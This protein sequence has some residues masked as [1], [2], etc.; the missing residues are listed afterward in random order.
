MSDDLRKRLGALT[1]AQRRL[2]ERRIAA[3]RRAAGAGALAAPI[4]KAAGDGPY[5]L[6]WSQERFWFLER[7]EPGNPAH[8][9]PGIALLAGPLD[10]D[11]F[12]AALELL[13]E[14]HAILRTIY[15]DTPDGPLQRVLPSA[16]LFFEIVDLRG[17]PP[18]ERENERARLEERTVLAPFDL[19]QGPVVRMRLLRLADGVHQLVSCLHH[20]AA[21]GLTMQILGAEAAAAYP[22]LVERR[23]PRLPALPVQYADYAVWQRTHLAGEHL[24]RG[25]AWWVERLAGLAELALPADRPRRGARADD[26]GK[27]RRALGR[28]AGLDL[29]D[30]LGARLRALA[31]AEGAT[32]FAVLLAAFQALL[33]RWTGEADVA[34]GTTAANRGRAELAGLVGFFVNT[35]VL[36]T[37]LAGDPSFRALLARARATSLGA[38]DHQDV[39]FERVVDALQPERSLEKH[40]LFQA[41]FNYVEFRGWT[42]PL[43]AGVSMEYRLAQAGTLFDLTLYATVHADRVRLDLEYAPDLFD[44]STVRRLLAH[45]ETFLFAVAADP[46]VPIGA[47]SILPPEERLALAAWS[48]GPAP[49]PIPGPASLVLHERFAARAAEHPERLALRDD[50][51]ELTYAAVEA[52]ANRLAHAL[53]ATGV[54]PGD[55]VG[56]ALERGVALVPAMLGIAKA[57]ACWVPL[58][59]AL[60]EARLRRMRAGVVRTLGAEDLDLDGAAGDPG[61]ID[62]GAIA[63]DAEACAYVLYTSGSTGVPKGVRVPHRALVRFLDAFAA[64]PGLGPDDRMLA[65]TTLAF[66]IALLELFGPLLVGGAVRVAARADASDGARLARLIVRER[67]TVMQ[68]TPATWRMLLYSGWRGR[69]DGDGLR[70]FCGGE[71]LP[72]DLADEL[73]DACDE[74]WNLYGPTETTVWSAADRVSSAPIAIGRPLAGETLLVRDAR[75][76]AAPIGVAGDLWIAGDG[77][78]LG[79][80]D[81]TLDAGR[82]VSGAYKTGDRARWRA[83]GRIEFLGRDDDQVKLRGFRI[84]L[85]DVEAALR[86]HPGVR[87]AACALRGDRLCAWF[88]PAGAAAPPTPELHE[89]LRERLPDYMLPGAIAAVAAL[90]LS[91]AGKLDRRA[92]PEPASVVAR[93]PEPA[94]SATERALQEIWAE[95]LDLDAP[96]AVGSIGPDDDFFELGGH[97]LLAARLAARIALRLDA[98]VP[99]QLFF[100]HPTIRGLAPHVE[101]A[102]ARATGSGAAIV[103]GARPRRV[104]LTFHQERLWFLDQLEGGPSAYHMPGAV[105]L[106]GALDADALA[107][108]LTEVVR[109]HEGL[110][111]VFVAGPA[112]APEQVVQAPAPF[113]LARAD[114]CAAANPEDA[115]R[116]IAAEVAARPFDLARGPLLRA[117]LVQTARRAPAEHV[118]VVCMHHVVSDGWSLGVLVR[119]TSALYAAFRAGAPSP[120]PELPVQMADLALWERRAQSR[121]ARERELA[122]WLHALRGA[123]ARLDLPTDHARPALPSHAGARLRV[124]L[125]TE[126]AARLRAFA[127]ARSASTF[128]ALLAAFQVLFARLAGADEVVLGTSVAGR[129]RPEV[130]GLIGFLVNAVPLRGRVDRAAPFA[131]HLE[132][133]RDVALAALEHA[134]LP[135]E[136]LVDAL[137]PPRDLTRQPVFQVTLD[138]LNVPA[139]P[140]TLAGLA[141]EEIALDTDRAKFDLS[142]LATDDAE[143]SCVLELSLDLFRPA[144]VARWWRALL[145][146]LDAA[147]DAP[148]TPC[149]ALPLLDADERASVLRLGSAGVPS[150]NAAS[151][152]TLH[153]LL[154]RAPGSADDTAVRGPGFELSRGALERRANF[155]AHRLRA[156]GVARGAAVGVCLGRGPELVPALLAVLRAG[157]AYVPLDPA[158]PARRLERIRVDAGCAVAIAD[159]ATAA[160]VN[161]ATL[162]RVD[163]EPGEAPCAPDVEVSSDDLAYVLYTSGS[164]GA[165]KGVEVSHGAVVHY[166]AAARERYAVDAGAGAPLA[167]SLGFDLT[168]TSLF[169]VLAAG[170]TVTLAAEGPGVAPLAATAAFP[171]QS[172]VKLTP[173]HLRALALELEPDVARGWTR[174][175]VVGGEALDYADLAFWRALAPDTRIFNEYGPTEATVGCIVFAVGADD[176][177]AGPVPIGRPLGAARAYVLDDRREPVPLGAPGE[178]WLAGPCLARGYRND[179]ELT[180]A[181]FAPD[182]FAGGGERMYRTGD[183]ARLRADGTFEYLGRLDEQVKVRG[184]RIEPAEVEAALRRGGAQAAAVALRDGRLCAWAVA[185]ATSSAALRAAVAAELPEAFV[186]SAILRLDALPLTAHGKVDVAALA[187]P[188][189]DAT[190]GAAARE[191]APARGAD[192]AALAEAFRITLGLDEGAV[193]RDDDFFALGG[194]SIL[195]LGIVARAAEHG[196]FLRPRDVFR[197][198][199]V[200]RLAAVASSTSD[201]ETSNAPLLGPIPLLPAQRWWC[202]HELATP[203]HWN[204]ALVLEARADLTPALLRA[205]LEVLVAHHDALRT[206]FARGADGGWRAAIVERLPAELVVSAAAPD[207]AEALAACHAGLDLARG[208]LQRATWFGRP[209][210]PALVVWSIHHLVVDGVSWRILLADLARIVAAL[211]DG[212]A[213][214]LPP[215]TAS[216]RRFAELAAA[217]AVAADT[218]V[219]AGLEGDA[220]AF[221]VEI[222]AVAT[223]AL[224]AAAGR[225]CRATLEDCLVAALLPEH[226][227]LDLESHG[228]GALNLARTVGWFTSL[229]TVRV[230]PSAEDGAGAVGRLK[231]AKEAVR[232]DKA[233]PGARTGARVLVNFHGDVDRGAELRDLPLR[234]LD[235]DPGPVRA[236]ANRRTHALEL[237]A[238]VADGRLRLDWRCTAADAAAARTLAERVLARL[239]ELRAACA[240]GAAG[241]TPSD[242]PL[243]GLDQVALDAL[244]TGLEDVLPLTPTQ[245]GMVFHGLRA[246]GSAAY[247]EQLANVLEGDL[248]AA[249]LRAAF[250]ALAADCEL[251]RAR[252]AWRGLREPLLLVATQDAF[253]P[254]PW[255]EVDWSDRDWNTAR[256][257]LDELCAAER[258]QGIDVEHGPLFRV[259]LA[260]LPAGRHALVWTYHHLVLDGWSMPLVLKRVLDAYLGGERAARSAPI[261]AWREYVEWL[262]AQDRDAA[263]VFWRERLAGFARRT[264]V[265]PRAAESASESGVYGEIERFLDGAETA[266]LVEQG[267]ALGVTLSTLVQ[268]AW[269]L[270][271]ARTS[272]ESDVLFGATV[273]GRPAELGRIDE[274]I[275]LFINTLPVRVHVDDDARVDAWLRGLQ[276]QRAEEIAFEWTP[277]LLAQACADVARGAPLFD[278]LVVF[279][280][281]PLDDALRAPPGGLRVVETLAF[282]RTSYS[283]TLVCVPGASLTLRLLFDEGRLDAVEAARLVAAVRA[284]LDGL[285]AARDDRVGA[286]GVLDPAERQALLF[287]LPTG[288]PLP[289][290]AAPR[291]PVHRTILARAASTPERIALEQGDVRWSYGELAERVA[292]LSARVAAAGVG[293]GDVVALLLPRSPEYVCA[294]LAVLR[295]G[296]AFLPLDVEHPPARRAFQVA[297]A[298]ARLVVANAALRAEASAAAG[299]DGRRVLAIDADEPPAPP[300]EC[301][302]RAD[303]DSVAY[304]LYTS[305]STG[306][307]KGVAVS[308]RSLAHYTAV[309]ADAYGVAASDRA[310]QLAALGFDT[311]LEEILPTLVRGATLVLRGDD[312]LASPKAFARM[313]AARGITLLNFPTALW[314][315]LALGF[316]AADAANLRG[317]RGA[318][319]G[320]EALLPGPLARWRALGLDALQLWN[321]YGPTEATIVATMHALE[322]AEATAPPIGRPIAGARAYVVDD[323]LRLVPRGYSGELVLAGPGVALG[324]VGHARGDAARFPADVFPGARDGDRLYRTGDRARWNADGELEF[325]G[326]GDDQVKVRG[327]RVELGEV[328]RALCDVPGIAQAAVLARADAGGRTTLAAWVVRARGAAPA[329]PDEI[330]RVLRE[331]VPAELVPARL[332]FLDALPRNAGGKIDRARLADGPDAVAVPAEAA[333][334]P[335]NADEA[336]VCALF[337]ESLELE[338]VGPHD[339][340]FALGGDSLVAVRFLGLFGRAFGVELPLRDL[341]EGPTPAEIALTLAALRGE[342]DLARVRAA[343]APEREPDLAAEATLPADVAPADA[344]APARPPRVVLLT[345]ATGFLGAHLVPEL[346]ARMPA[347]ARLVA[348][349]RAKDDAQARERLLATLARYEI[350]VDAARVEALAGDLGAPGL[351]LDAARRARLAGEIDAIVHAGAEVGFLKPYAALKPANVAGTLELLRLACAGRATAFHHVS[352]VGVFDV[353]RPPE[354]LSEDLDLDRFRD[355]RGGYAQSKWVAE[356]LVRAAAERG[357]DARILRPGRLVASAATGIANAGDVAHEVLRACVALGAAPDLVLELDA[358]PVDFAA[359]AIAHLAQIAFDADAPPGAAFH[360][361]HAAELDPRRSAAALRAAGCAVELVRPA[362]WWRRLRKRA[363]RDGFAAL[364]PLLAELPELRGAAAAPAPRVEDARARAALAAAGIACPELDEA[365]LGRI[366]RRIRDAR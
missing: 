21:D 103:A 119:E 214:A 148:E 200:A 25:L 189:A 270:V 106:V 349:V 228:R 358:T 27:E 37:D 224:A 15:D 122:W 346:L 292:A 169:P 154:R 203:E 160:L 295:A 259:V 345:G 3:R 87:D 153:E 301:D 79:Y 338:R 265:G 42:R 359:R 158:A 172:L 184:V 93:A 52:A 7:L 250:T 18:S 321:T 294:L 150:A 124:A 94:S 96:C 336:R 204:Q 198:P 277:L 263:R 130:E 332:A 144:T 85:G 278:S 245:S 256:A 249:A 257:R 127:R 118:L 274:R 43:G 227:A 76:G 105:R 136:R 12:R 65:V 4:E 344:R 231:R 99:L 280:N 287:E 91:P 314:H 248:D 16:P 350:V 129:A 13:V 310:L 234:P 331:R 348:L 140:V 14:R 213:P 187:T 305:G 109:R 98:E 284:A 38:Q 279:E 181:R 162:L 357:L 185:P 253:G 355:V 151:A 159:E 170:R 286:V 299:D 243:A 226:G 50:E 273:A 341:F 92:L 215:R 173:A 164:T 291:E 342:R 178:L 134:E 285:A 343:R 217:T 311:S 180:A 300:F 168:V 326:R 116:A 55:R 192:E 46:D 356:R 95:A 179:P 125:G 142:I 351:G 120:L 183:R 2:L 236:A 320:G 23:A 186:P 60:P 354:R 272:G 115:W 339:D 157:A 315:E 128:H 22:A 114:V 145:L 288:P 100:A 165:P 58:D 143:L 139:A 313:V 241:L 254:L 84:E 298:A 101:A 171:G 117:S 232:A 347:D 112:G 267:R 97:S 302:D 152:G 67:P 121:P 19:A 353:D 20:I 364:V 206:T 209:G 306:A 335:R 54:K 235:R 334:A 163:R 147:L 225:A 8:H 216:V 283:A 141:V 41:M 244:G 264:P 49:R 318:I 102:R 39:P 11:A 218:G 71:A 220:V 110:R 266:R 72:R 276:A 61:P 47:V 33:F 242:V 271:L 193:G 1:P 222:D 9:L 219:D 323:A 238:R 135:F 362:D 146:L 281:Y 223:G 88:V 176:P 233:I 107:R 330:L 29:P 360:V 316:D 10:V 131:E 177:G 230:A 74:V 36:R 282:E 78:A 48:A 174:A 247:V 307:P 366:A 199:T 17:L 90:P 365:Y 6:S 211:A 251:L 32:L 75:G 138:L 126:R 269:A 352:T 73:L 53:C 137:R 133:A 167:S 80:T 293:P 296:A 208:P 111:T 56:I 237:N 175:L 322:R 221:S 205:A 363:A 149:G 303:L 86:A 190:G 30:A 132:R 212:R 328:E 40:P 275:G 317:V 45:L 155:L 308:H 261:P 196:L 28:R 81:P 161:G 290:G 82:F 24:E 252:V 35:L 329:T 89:H 188:G 156:L 5:P 333:A 104:P 64:L 229:R 108:A 268:A 297:D 194:D 51:R 59:P 62:P 207:D 319:L 361:V 197:H 57:G 240:A 68:A 113:A 325:L 83:D 337:A 123:P 246:P 262:R 340:F 34:V 309:A 258:A 327:R 289:P 201:D 255:R 182:P 324:Y 26:P 304:V 260:R 166:V 191:T 195:V 210:E 63:V 69:D 70:A 66:D 239:D 44:A 202:A 312:D 77:V 31:R